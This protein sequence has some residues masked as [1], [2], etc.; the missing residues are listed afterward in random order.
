M[1][2]MSDDK[3]E[4]ENHDDYDRDVEMQDISAPWLGGQRECSI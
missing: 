1:Q 4:N 3:N 2:R